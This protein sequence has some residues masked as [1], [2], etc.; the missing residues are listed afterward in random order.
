[1]LARRCLLLALIALLPL[2]A[3]A[4]APDGTASSATARRRA[5][6]PPQTELEI[7][8]LA[9]YDTRDRLSDTLTGLGTSISTESAAIFWIGILL[10]LALGLKGAI[11]RCT[12]RCPQFWQTLG[13]F[14]F[15]LNFLRKQIR[16]S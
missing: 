16:S 1:M 15:D 5:L 8:A 6:R 12:H 10:V 3:A 11:R 4:E 13:P 2:T 7:Y 14:G 9:G